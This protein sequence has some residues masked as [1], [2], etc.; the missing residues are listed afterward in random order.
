LLR[1]HHISAIETSP[2]FST[3]PHKSPSPPKARKPHS[4]AALNRFIPIKGFARGIEPLSAKTPD[5]PA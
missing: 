5:F 4:Y 1:F 3:Q 2:N